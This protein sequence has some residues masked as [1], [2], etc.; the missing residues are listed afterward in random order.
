MQVSD[1]LAQPGEPGCKRNEECSLSEACLNAQC[2]NPC[3]VG[4]P[5]ALTANCIPLNHKAMC[6]CP[7]GLEGDPFIRCY[8]KPKI[9]PEC[10]SDSECS[11]D[12]SCINQACQNPC[13]LANPCGSNA[14]CQTHYHRPSCNCP[15]GWVGNPQVQCY[16]CNILI[17]SFIYLNNCFAYF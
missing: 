3:A 13:T 16:K 2:V 11:N 10:T 15:N 12:K 9:R 7:A 5:C 14:E 6:K 8:E 17:L 4:N 1:L